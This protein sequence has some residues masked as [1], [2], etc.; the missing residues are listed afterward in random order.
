MVSDKQYW[1]GGD[2]GRRWGF[3]RSMDRL[4]KGILKKFAQTIRMTPRF[5]SITNY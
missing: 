1:S 2:D 5:Q 3:P 4:G